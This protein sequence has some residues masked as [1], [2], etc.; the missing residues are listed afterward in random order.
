MPVKKPRRLPKKYSRRVSRDT[1]R[2][3]KKRMQPKKVNIN[4]KRRRLVRRFW[5]LW[6]ESRPKAARMIAASVMILGVVVFCVLLFSP[7]IQVRE[8]QVVRLSPR[9]DIEQVQQAL[10]PTFGRHLVF[11]SSFEVV[12]LLEEHIADVESVSIGKTYPSKLHVRIELHPL[13]ARLTIVRPDDEERVSQDLDDAGEE[14]QIDFLTDRGIYVATTAAQDTETLPEILIVDWGIRPQ[15]GTVLID[16]SFLERMNAA[17]WTLLRQFGQEVTRRT[18]FVRAQEF[19]LKTG[20]RELW[21]DLRS[22]LEAQLERYRTFL[23]ETDLDTVQEYIDLRISD[24][25][26]Y[27]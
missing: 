5:Q 1:K 2:F 9:L 23:T 3:V 26:L 13:V 27:Q 25:V 18:V 21:F 17:E 8:I 16:P 7:L 22:P 19:H 12:K 20:Q 24:R 10:V 15:E 14:L 6:E 11:L 4:Q